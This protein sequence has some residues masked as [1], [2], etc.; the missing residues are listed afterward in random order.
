MVCTCMRCETPELWAAWSRRAR[1]VVAR[2]LAHGH[3]IDTERYIGTLALIR[4]IDGGHPAS[5]SPG[6]WHRSHHQRGCQFSGRRT[7]MAGVDASADAACAW[8]RQCNP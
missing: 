3:R 1:P 4:G 5:F 2:L 6:N 8:G 7:P